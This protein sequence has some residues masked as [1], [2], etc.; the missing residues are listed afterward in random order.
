[1]EFLKNKKVLIGLGVAVLAIGVV[2]FFVLKP[3]SKTT[4]TDKVPDAATT[5]AVLKN[6]GIGTGGGVEIGGASIV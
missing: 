1:M 2:L 4:S 6:L 3:K 5:A